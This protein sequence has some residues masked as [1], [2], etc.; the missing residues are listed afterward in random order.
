MNRKRSN[1]IA[2]LLNKGMNMLNVIWVTATKMVVVSPK[3]NQRLSNG[4]AKRRN[5]G[6]PVQ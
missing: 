3:M 1:G 5:K 2:R 6:V 4:I